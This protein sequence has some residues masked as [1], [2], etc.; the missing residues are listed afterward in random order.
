MENRLL[1]LR[2]QCEATLDD[3]TR[4]KLRKD[5]S[6]ACSSLTDYKHCVTPLIKNDACSTN[7]NLISRLLHFSRAVVGEYQMSCKAI[8]MKHI[9]EAE[10]VEDTACLPEELRERVLTCQ[11][12][13]YRTI[14]ARDIHSETDICAELDLMKECIENALKESS[15]S[16]DGASKQ[17]ADDTMTESYARYNVKCRQ[18]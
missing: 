8:A 4:L 10:E 14:R 11:Q 15:C 5:Q 13:A 18:Y 6:E 12:S 17:V 1:R 16:R 7:K 9:M 3:V 2:L